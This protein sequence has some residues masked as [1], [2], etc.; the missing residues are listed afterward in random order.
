MFG[1]SNEPTQ[2]FVSYKG[3]GL[4]VRTPIRPLSRIHSPNGNL[5]KFSA[6]NSMLDRRRDSNYKNTRMYIKVLYR[7]LPNSSKNKIS[8]IRFFITILFWSFK[9]NVWK[10]CVASYQTQLGWHK[11]TTKA[12]CY[13]SFCCCIPSTTTDNEQFVILLHL[14]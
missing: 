11:F 1:F 5:L 13:T 14:L 9:I 4:F 10:P 6:G 12:F 3:V 8:K 7:S 2:W